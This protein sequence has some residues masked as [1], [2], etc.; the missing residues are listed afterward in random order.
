[1]I[2]CPKRIDTHFGDKMSCTCMGKGKPVKGVAEV[3]AGMWRDSVYPI[4]YLVPKFHVPNPRAK[5]VIN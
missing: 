2:I 5:T 3:M 1:M 4:I